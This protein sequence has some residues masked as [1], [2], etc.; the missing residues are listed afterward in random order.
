[1]Y[2]SSEI[3]GTLTESHCGWSGAD[4]I[5]R[6]TGANKFGS[7]VHLIPGMQYSGIYTGYKEINM[8]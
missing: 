4:P 8:V 6:Y 5:F 1:M 2:P 3:Y 7:S